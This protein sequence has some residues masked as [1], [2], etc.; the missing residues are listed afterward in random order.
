MSLLECLWVPPIAK[1]GCFVVR[2][3]SFDARLKN[4]EVTE[5]LSLEGLKP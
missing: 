5:V 4:I 3:L 1:E 2:L